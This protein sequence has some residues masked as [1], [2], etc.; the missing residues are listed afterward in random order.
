MGT[1]RI[2]RNYYKSGIIALYRALLNIK[3]NL[4]FYM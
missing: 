2:I 4:Y 1:Y 3:I